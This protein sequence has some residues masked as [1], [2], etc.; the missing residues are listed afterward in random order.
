MSR[1]FRPFK[2]GFKGIGRHIGIS[3]SSIFAVA[4]TLILVGTFLLVNEN[5]VSI[6]SNI[7]QNVEIYVEIN[8]EYD[9]QL[10]DLKTQVE[11]LRNVSTSKI[12]TREESLRIM[13]EEGGE[14]YRAYEGENNPLPNSMLVTLRTGSDIRQ[15]ADLLEDFPW[16]VKTRYGGVETEN[17]MDMMIRLR[18]I[19]S[20]F[21]VAL[22]FLAILLITNTIKVSIESRAEEISIMRIV[23][24]T[25]WFIKSPFLIEG[26]LIGLFGAI[27]PIAFV[28]FGYQMLYNSLGGVLFSNMFV[29]TPVLPMVHNISLLLLGLAVGVGMLG[30]FLSI[31]KHLKVVR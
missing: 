16:V 25:N 27:F 26:I 23:G 8:K 4:V 22:G 29:M 19:G 13:I 3:I 30:S 12:V 6:S 1:I 9:D 7:E 15:T 28:Y 10:V 2:E 31:N 11:K 14:G 18:S 24:A 21:V 5:V 17:M 20:V